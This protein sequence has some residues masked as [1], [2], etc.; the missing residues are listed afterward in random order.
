ME[1]ILKKISIKNK[2]LLQNLLQLYLH[3]ISKD[4]SVGID[5]DQYQ[6]RNK[7]NYFGIK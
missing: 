3:D 4:F 6:I 2:G 1:I 5:L 7:L